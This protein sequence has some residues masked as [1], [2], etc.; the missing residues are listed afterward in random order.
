MISARATTADQRQPFNHEA[1]NGR[2][3]CQIG[4]THY[5]PQQR[6]FTTKEWIQLRD[7]VRSL[8]AT[9]KVPLAYE[10]DEPKR[11]PLIDNDMIRFNGVGEDGHETFVIYRF[12]DN[13]YNLC[14]TAQKPYDVIVTAI[15]T[16]ANT[17]A[18]G[19]LKISSD[20]R[21]EDWAAGVK[22]AGSVRN[23]EMMIPI[24]RDGK[25]ACPISDEVDA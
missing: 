3:E 24:G 21:P 10:A 7:V 16:L 25:M 12:N 22:L 6:N 15:L 1:A 4:Y 13:S 18:P 2:G 11:K 8:I 5:F 20:G 9:T 17:L 14:K 19:A 23:G